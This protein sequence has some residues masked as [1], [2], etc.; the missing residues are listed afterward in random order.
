MLKNK[1][2]K[3]TNRIDTEILK[4]ILNNDESVEEGD[5]RKSL[6]KDQ[7]N[8]NRYL[9]ELEE[10]GYIEHVQIMKGRRKYNLWNITKIE[11]L[12]NIRNKLRWIELNH[13]EKSLKIVLKKFNLSI[14]TPEGFKF[15]IRLF[16]SAFFFDVCLKIELESFYSRT[17]GIYLYE[18]GLKHN[19]TININLDRCYDT[20]IKRNPS[21]YISREKF[22]AVVEEIFMNICEQKFPGWLKS[23]PEKTYL[24]IIAGFI[25]KSNV[26]LGEMLKPCVDRFPG[27]VK[28][29][30]LEKY[31]RFSKIVE[32][33]KNELFVKTSELDSIWKSCEKKFPDWFKEIPEEVYMELLRKVIVGEYFTFEEIRNICNEQFPGVPDEGF[34]LELERYINILNDD[35]T[36]YVAIDTAA[37]S[38]SIRFFDFF[39]LRFDLIFDHCFYQDLITGEPSPVEIEFAKKTKENFERYISRP[40]SEYNHA[41]FQKMLKNDLKQA[42]I[43]MAKYKQPRISSKKISDNP[44]EVYQDL[45]EFFSWHLQPIAGT[46]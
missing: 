38:M 34:F 1:E 44:E 36:I 45:I 4:F 23:M 6:G 2:V 11:H 46:N 13:Y 12:K 27:W 7:G 41:S 14:N 16:V 42:S 33:T 10:L 21:S 8:M 40:E 37:Y 18:K 17:W 39:M 22:H 19:Q 35:R 9:R 15:Y 20:Y 3:F 28:E 43:V 31:L 26:F 24:R 30:P 32:R 25:G 5:I 29:M